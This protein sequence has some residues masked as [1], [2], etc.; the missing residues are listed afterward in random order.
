MMPRETPLA[1]WLRENEIG[2]SEFAREMGKVRGKHVWPS[3][4]NGIAVGREKAGL[5]W[6]HW[7]E[8]STKGQ[9]PAGS[10]K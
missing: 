10:W 7:I 5:W 9:V 8:R 2:Q 3:H 4:I 6:K 1:K